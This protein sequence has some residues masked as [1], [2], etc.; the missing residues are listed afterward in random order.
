MPNTVDTL[1]E[2][3]RLRKLITDLHEQI[4]GGPEA[5]AAEQ[6]RV[7]QAE[8]DLRDAQDRLK[9]LKVAVHDKE[10]SLK[11]AHQ[12]IA[13]YEKQRET[14]GSKK[15]LDAFDHEISHSR[16]KVAELEEKRSEEQT[17]EL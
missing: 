3:H 7:T 10:T 11:A 4:A 12:Q 5:L 16:Q 14:A 2:I 17:A 9:H 13:K 6:A 8:T 1:R 15:E